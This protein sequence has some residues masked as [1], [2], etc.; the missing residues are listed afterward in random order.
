MD[1]VADLIAASA[2]VAR[3]VEDIVD[4]AGTVTVVVAVVSVVAEVSVVAGCVVELSVVDGTTVV[5]TIAA[6][7]V[8]ALQ[9]PSYTMTS[10]T[11]MSPNVPPHT[12]TSVTSP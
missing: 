8:G 5:V 2:A 12:P 1:I 4:V 3:G 9:G 11:A 6:A 7:V 10:S